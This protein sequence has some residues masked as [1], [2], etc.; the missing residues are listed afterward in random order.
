MFQDGLFYFMESARK[1][2]QIIFHIAQGIDAQ[3]I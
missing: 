3:V 2:P 1:L